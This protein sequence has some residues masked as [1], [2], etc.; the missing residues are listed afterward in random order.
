MRVRSLRPHTDHNGNMVPPGVVYD[1][2]DQRAR[3]IAGHGYAELLNAAN[4]RPNEPARWEHEHGRLLSPFGWESAYRPAV[5]AGT[6]PR[7]LQLTRY[8]PGAAAYR[9]HSAFNT[10]PGGTS[11]FARYGHENPMCDLRQY[12]GERNAGQVQQF[13]ATADVVHVHMDYNTLEQTLRR[14][15]DRE[16]QL[17]VRHYHG[18]QSP[19]AP[20][21]TWLVQNELD[22]QVGAVQVGARLYHN[23][24]SERMHWLPIPMPVQD[25]AALRQRLWKPIDARPNRCVRIAHSPTHPRIKGTIALETIVQDLRAK[26]LLIE[27]VMI[28]GKSHGEAL[29]IKATCDITFDSFWLGIQ[30]SGLEAACMSQAVIA[31]DSE[32]KAEYE[33]EMGEC[34][35]SFAKDAT[36]LP[37]VLER[38]VVDVDHRMREAARVMDYVVQYHDYPAVGARYWAVLEAAQRERS[39]VAA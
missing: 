4:V 20:K 38:L 3:E 23:R 27:L 39:L 21:E 11:V 19:V 29:A 26:G 13:F 5:T 8:D 36:E 1:T 30:G 25:Y 17:L 32:V 12:D 16:R 15:P 9:Y 37:E 10:A 33:R 7:V 22:E 28:H 31:G 34:P 24:F 6:P 14:W 18:S 2:P 35:Y